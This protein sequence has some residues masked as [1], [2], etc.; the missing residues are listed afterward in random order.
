[1]HRPLD[2]P[3][4]TTL[5]GGTVQQPYGRYQLEPMSPTS[6]ESMRMVTLRIKLDTNMVQ[7]ETEPCLMFVMSSTVVLLGMSSAGLMLHG[8]NQPVFTDDVSDRCK[9]LNGCLH[10]FYQKDLQLL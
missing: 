7:G 10:L 6:V 4:V 1:M 8:M 9:L 5:S 3:G 2:W